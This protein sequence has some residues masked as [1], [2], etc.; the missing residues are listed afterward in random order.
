MADSHDIESL[1]TS[2][3]AAGDLEGKLIV[4]SNLLCLSQRMPVDHVTK[5]NIF[6]NDCPK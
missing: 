4:T 3:M 6:P 2:R 5:A 1:R